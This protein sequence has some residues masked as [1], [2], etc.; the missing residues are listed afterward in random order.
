[1]HTHE[2]DP[3]SLA[4]VSHGCSNQASFY[5]AASR[6]TLLALDGC[7][8]LVPAQPQRVKSRRVCFL[9]LPTALPPPPARRLPSPNTV[10]WSVQSCPLP[11]PRGRWLTWRC[12]FLQTDTSTPRWSSTGSCASGR[13]TSATSAPS[14]STSTG[15]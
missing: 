4:G 10:P 5:V 3:R 13:S 15:C 6:A 9:C 2:T 1:M 8:R 7:S 14:S 12:L 11:S